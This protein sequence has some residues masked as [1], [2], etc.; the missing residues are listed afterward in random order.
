MERVGDVTPSPDGR[1]VLFSR[2]TW[3]REVDKT[4]ANLWIVSID[5]ATMLQLT[6]AGYHIDSSSVWSPDGRS[7]AFVSNRGGSQQIWTV[8]V[9]EGK[10]R[11]LTDFPLDVGNL[12]WSPTGA[13]ISFSSDVYLNAS[14]FEATANRD[15]ES[16]NDPMRFDRLFVRHWDSW[17]RGKRS[18]IFLL[19]VKHEKSGWIVDGAPIDLM[20]GVDGDCPTKPFGGSE[21]YAW[22]PDGKEIAYTT[23]LGNDEA[24]CTDLNIY[25]V[26]V[27]GNDVRC[28]TSENRA[29]DTQPVYSPNGRTIAYL[30]TERPGYESDRRRIKLYERKSSETRTLTE[31]WDRSPS[32]LTWSPDGKEL[33]ATVSETGRQKIFAIDAI[34]GRPRIVVCDHYNFNV[35]AIADTT[36]PSRSEVGCRLVFEEA[37]LTEP[38]EIWTVASDGSNKRR[39]TSINYERLKLSLTSKPEEFFFIGAL[40]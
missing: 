11:Q 7:V 17:S 20:K 28:I 24:W 9:D 36:G 4:S 6:S 13:Y 22:S 34:S 14:D 18:H 27:S 37:S 21:E 26:S 15:K 35:H 19:P 1:W 10:A 16:A 29:I 8:D 25:L 31:A 32:S 33:Y 2:K 3:N 5:G 30:A 39:L 23:H 38:A 12:R 40:G